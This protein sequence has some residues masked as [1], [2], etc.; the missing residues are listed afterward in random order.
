MSEQKTEDSPKPER[1]LGHYRVLDQ[2]GQGGMAVVYKGVQASLNRQVAIKV[3]PEH[4]AQAPEMVSR[5][6]REASVAAQLKHPSIVQVIDRGKEGSTL[7]IVMEYVEGES[8]DKVIERG[9]LSLEDTIDYCVQIC[10]ALQYAHEKG[11]VH[12]DLKPANILLDKESGRAKIA[13]F[14]IATL[15]TDTVESLTLTMDTRSLGTLH[16]MSPE[17]QLDAHNVTHQTDIFAFGV[18]LYEMLTGRV[19]IGHFKLPS[20][21]RSDIPIALDGIVSRCM[22]E[23]PA[24]RY[25]DAGEI[26]E[27]LLRLTGRP[28]RTR[29]GRSRPARSRRRMNSFLVLLVLVVILAGGGGALY[30]LKPWQ[31]YLGGHAQAAAPAGPPAPSTPQGAAPLLKTANAAVKAGD[32]EAARRSANQVLTQFPGSPEAAEA[33]KLIDQLDAQRIDKDFAATVDKAKARVAPADAGEEDYMAALALLDEASRRMPNHADELAANAQSIRTTWNNAFDAAM[34]SGKQALQ[35]SKWDEATGAFMRAQHLRA[36]P[37]AEKGLT[38]VKRASELAGFSSAPD[39]AAR[40]RHLALYLA[41]GSS[42]ADARLVPKA[43]DLRALVEQVQSAAK[44]A[45]AFGNSMDAAARGTLSTA[46]TDFAQAQQKL[47]KLDPTHLAEPDLSASTTDFRLALDGYHGA[48]KAALDQLYP[49]MQSSQPA[50]RLMALYKAKADY[51]DS[52]TIASD[53]ATAFRDGRLADLAKELANAEAAAPADRP[54]ALAAV[55]ADC[56]KQ[57]QAGADADTVQSLKCLALVRRSTALTAAGQSAGALQDALSAAAL[58]PKDAGAQQALKA[59]GDALAADLRGTAAEPGRAAS[60]LQQVAPLL[61]QTAA[62]PVREQVVKVAAEPDFAEALLRQPVLTRAWEA[63]LGPFTPPGMVR[64]AGGPFPLGVQYTGLKAL[65][66]SS[67]PQHT[68]ALPDYCIDVHEVTNAQFAAFVAAGGYANDEYLDRLPRRRARGVRGLD[69]QARAPL[70]G[71]RH[72]PGQRRGPAGL[73]RQL[74]RG[75]RLRPVGRRAAADGG[76]VGVRRLRR[77]RRGRGGRA[78]GRRLHGTAVPVGQPVRRRP[79]QPGRRRQGRAL[80]SRLLA[81]R[82]EPGRLLRHGRQRARVDGQRLRGLSELGVPGPGT[83]HR[84]DCG[85]GP[86]LCRLPDRRRAD[87]PARHGQE[88]TGREDRLPLCV[89]AAD[90]VGARAAPPATDDS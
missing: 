38:D 11:V 77:P 32:A 8:L 83:R 48:I 81:G 5:F 34:A 76:R 59:A 69:R 35:Q 53:Y 36:D 86:Q 21:V 44:E 14:G 78:G 55:V 1:T 57:A 51:P 15:Q 71:Q 2:I 79:R 39:A 30:V 3:L 22:A 26:K 47:K 7:Y 10:E 60:L 62:G 66:P 63:A 56:D 4:F 46:E 64:I 28:R 87:Q 49:G 13:D 20:L 50:D 67:A 12:R 6:D 41:M 68:V 18:M 72:L 16:Y 88:G 58:S 31:K 82:Q 9:P 89:V 23:S 19:P 42:E 75:G 65:T 54:G 85:A 37:A 29:L 74:V 80:G 84:P 17:Q 24:D 40:M 73:G 25:Q 90:A 27:E 61:T 43:Q 45:T 33:R 70:L 52:T